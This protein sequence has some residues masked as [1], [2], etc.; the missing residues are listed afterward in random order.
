MRG[1]QPHRALPA[2]R[3][4]KSSGVNLPTRDAPADASVK[5]NSDA[6]KPHGTAS[7]GQVWGPT[8][9]SASAKHPMPTRP[10]PI[11]PSP[12]TRP[13]A[14]SGRPPSPPLPIRRRARPKRLAHGWPTTVWLVRRR[15]PAHAASRIRRTDQA[16]RWIHPVTS[17]VQPTPTA[18]RTPDSTTSGPP[19]A[20]TTGD[21]QS[22]VGWFSASRRRR[23]SALGKTWWIVSSEYHSLFYKVLLISA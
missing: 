5:T 15:Q 6:G 12:T 4:V 10:A 19:T 14:A 21:V 7:T 3:E 20:W 16:K 1:R 9:R 11:G 2:R 22:T 13:R 17:H 18:G 23:Y 8:A